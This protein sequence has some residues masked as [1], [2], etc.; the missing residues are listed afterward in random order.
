MISTCQWVT[1]STFKSIALS[2]QVLN[3]YQQCRLQLRTYYNC[4]VDCG[5]KDVL[6]SGKICQ[7]MSWE[8]ELELCCIH[9]EYKCYKIKRDLP[10]L[11]LQLSHLSLGKICQHMSWETELELCCIHQENK[12]Y[13]INRDLPPLGLQLSHSTEKVRV[14]AHLRLHRVLQLSQRCYPPGGG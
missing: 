1:S 4:S 10:P 7:H 14:L 6:S 8:K 11:Y 9:Q 3:P 12:C 13:K 2:L 5:T